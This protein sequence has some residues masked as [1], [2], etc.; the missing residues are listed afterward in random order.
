MPLQ[1]RGPKYGVD[2][3]SKRCWRA[4]RKSARQLARMMMPHLRQRVK[5]VVLAPAATAAVCVGPGQCRWALDGLAAVGRRVDG[6]AAVVVAAVDVAV[7]GVSVRAGAVATTA[8]A[9]TV[10]RLDD[11]RCRPLAA[12]GRADG[13]DALLRL[14]ITNVWYPQGA[15]ARP[16]QCAASIGNAWACTGCMR[17]FPT[18]ANL[19]AHFRGQL[20]R[21]AFVPHVHP[22]PGAPAAAGVYTPAHIRPAQGDRWTTAVHGRSRAQR[23]PP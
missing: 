21:S 12:W 13:A 6:H 1:Q 5:P 7:N 15:T 14:P 3:A 9:V 20:P 18:L 10:A 17:R 4:A 2:P 19:A 11:Q 16:M 22:A 23:A 8:N